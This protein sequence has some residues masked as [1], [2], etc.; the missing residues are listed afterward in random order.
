[1]WAD[2]DKVNINWH[3]I[4]LLACSTNTEQTNIIAFFAPPADKNGI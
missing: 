3:V 2:V 1:M 4:H